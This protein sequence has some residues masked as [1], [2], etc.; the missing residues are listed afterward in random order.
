MCRR[1]C[2]K[3]RNYPIITSPEI[4]SLVLSKLGRSPRFDIRVLDIH[5]AIQVREV[6]ITTLVN[7][8]L[9]LYSGKRRKDDLR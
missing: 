8:C 7:L 1:T 4:L 3:W 6:M 2:I 9:Y 5:T